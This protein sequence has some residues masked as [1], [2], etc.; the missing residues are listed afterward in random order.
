[1]E[2]LGVHIQLKAHISPTHRLLFEQDHFHSQMYEASQEF[3]MRNQPN[4]E[5]SSIQMLCITN[6][7]I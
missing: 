6:N 2:V 7:T 4:L 1:M 3:N 5:M